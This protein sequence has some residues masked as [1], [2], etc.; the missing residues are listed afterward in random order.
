[1]MQFYNLHLLEEA[2]VEVSRISV[3]D[4]GTSGVNSFFTYIYNMNINDACV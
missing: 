2:L 4:L 3:K 1:M